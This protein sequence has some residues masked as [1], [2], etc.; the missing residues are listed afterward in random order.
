MHRLLNTYHCLAQWTQKHFILN[1]NF[2]QYILKTCQTDKL[3]AKSK[4][5]D[6][7]WIQIELT[8]LQIS[9]WEIWSKGSWDLWV[10]LSSPQGRFLPI[11]LLSMGIMTSASPYSDFLI[12]ISNENTQ[13]MSNAHH[14]HSC[15][16]QANNSIY[17][18]Q[19]GQFSP[20]LYVPKSSL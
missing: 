1:K 15:I 8:G 7:S 12:N 2:E 17:T 20:W 11:N 16:K 3:S 19:A 14:P 4:T 18:P 9:L 10:C 5:K 13:L 6:E